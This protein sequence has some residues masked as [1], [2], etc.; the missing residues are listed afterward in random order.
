MRNFRLFRQTDYQL[1]LLLYGCLSTVGITCVS[2]WIRVHVQSLPSSIIFY[3]IPLPLLSFM[4]MHFVFSALFRARRGKTWRRVVLT[5]ET[6]WVVFPILFEIF[7]LRLYQC[8]YDTYVGVI[9][10][11]SN[12]SEA[13]EYFGSLSLLRVIFWWGLNLGLLWGCWKVARPLQQVWTRWQDKRCCRAAWHLVVA[14]ALLF[15]IAFSA[16]SAIDLLMGNDVSLSPR[17]TNASER[18][19]WGT[20]AVIR[21]RV[22]M[23]HHMAKMNDASHFR[24][25]TYV[26]SLPDSTEVVVILGES[27]RADLMSAYGYERSTTP[28]ME[29]QAQQ[30]DIVLFDD[31]A[32][33][34]PSTVESSQRIF[35]FWD[36]REGRQWYDFPDLTHLMSRAGFTT[37]WLTNQSCK[38]IF[39]VERFLTSQADRVISTDGSIFSKGASKRNR[40][41]DNSFD[42]VLLPLVKRD[43][44]CRKPH[45][46]R[47]E[48]FTV[49][50]L[51]GSHFRYA[52]RYPQSFAHFRPQDMKECGSDYL[53][54][55]KA[56]YL[57]SLR[58][59]DSL[60]EKMMEHYAKKRALVVYLSDHSEIVGDPGYGDFIGHSRNVKHESVDVPFFVYMSPQLRQERPEMWAR[61]KKAQFRPVSTAWFT[62]SL[63]ALLGIRTKYHDERYN[64]FSDSFAQPDR[65]AVHSGLRCVVPPAQK[66]RVLPCP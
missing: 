49:I 61:I 7:L 3:S 15:S 2:M 35:T 11:A 62:N 42:E 36:S 5:L 38:N 29:Q 41:Q 47:T 8:Y 56:A 6:V 63:T 24:G 1:A 9:I 23:Q 65:I 16:L 59:T 27:A 14:C 17:Y 26:P 44:I 21:E 51:M 25:M 13:S 18:V 33:A 40:Q 50:H 60:L 48:Q 52:T 57:N 43:T 30:G 32:C 39:S 58:Y 34:A 22:A 10:F 28:W 20:A 45:A 12:P 54:G 64:F 19:W 37:Q 66:R 4:G 53:K 55:E 46:S 31:V